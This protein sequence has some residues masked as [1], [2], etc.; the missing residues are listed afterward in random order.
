MPHQNPQVPGNGALLVLNSGYMGYI[1]G[2]LGGPGTVAK[3]EG[4]A[5][6][7]QLG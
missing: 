7:P 3:L 1:R 2:W 5:Y 4:C 6:S